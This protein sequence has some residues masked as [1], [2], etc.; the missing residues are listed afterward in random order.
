MLIRAENSLFDLVRFDSYL[1]CQG[2]GP[3]ICILLEPEN[4]P[5]F[6]ENIPPFKVFPF[7][8]PFLYPERCNLLYFLQPQ[9]SCPRKV[10][11]QILGK[12]LG[13]IIIY[14]TSN[15]IDCIHTVCDKK[16]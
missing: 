11:V 16:V 15:L 12:R 8:T 9:E 2:L 1:S 13:K 4:I 10:I 7:Y 14:K 5:P 6:K 3:K